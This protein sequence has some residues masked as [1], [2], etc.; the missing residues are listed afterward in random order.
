MTSHCISISGSQQETDQLSSEILDTLPYTIS[1]L[2]YFIF[3][4][5]CWNLHRWLI[6]PIWLCHFSQV[7]VFQASLSKSRS[8]VVAITWKSS[9]RQ[10][11]EENGMK[12][13]YSTSLQYFEDKTNTQSLLYIQKRWSVQGKHT[14]INSY[15][16]V[17]LFIIWL[18]HT[19]SILTILNGFSLVYTAQHSN[20]AKDV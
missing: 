10:A 11:L 3:L 17:C 2:S 1:N 16:L 5:G 9:S 4:A 19:G 6:Y 20:L 15:S 18:R 7:P 14:D 8:R 13:H 12:R